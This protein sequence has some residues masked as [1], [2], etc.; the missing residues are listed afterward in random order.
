ME[1]CKIE[2]N[3]TQASFWM[4]VFRLEEGEYPDTRVSFLPRSCQHCDNAPCV[5]VCPVGA[6]FK[7]EDGLVLTDFER[8]IGCRYCVVAC[9]YG[10]NTFNWRDPEEGYYL[11]WDD[12]DLQPVTGG[13]VPPWRNPD[14]QVNQG[15]EE[16]LTAGGGHYQGVVEK[17]TF[18]VQRVEQDLD[19]ACVATCPV[20]ALVFGDL[21]DPASP[22]NAAM[23]GRDSFRLLEELGTEPRVH[24]VGGQPPG[25]DVREVERVNAEVSS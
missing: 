4:Y 7:R 12:P 20:Q 5:K 6:R 18:C 10:V 17:C 22:V 23:R 11:D 2:N 16:R 25:Q 9:P 19:P 3:T 15:E 13:A 1:A 14:L 21:D 24:F 8:C